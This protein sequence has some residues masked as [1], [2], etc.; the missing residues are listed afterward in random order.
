MCAYL[1]FL[2]FFLVFN[3]VKIFKKGW[4][5]HTSAWNSLKPQTLFMP[6][7]TTRSLAYAAE[8]APSK[9]VSYFLFTFT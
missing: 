4:P 5:G 8:Q 3:E 7:G 1:S 6:R 2:V 9:V